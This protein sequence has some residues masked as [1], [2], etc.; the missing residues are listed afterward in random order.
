MEV[1]VTGIGLVSALGALEASWRRLL[2]GNS[3]I[4][5]YQP[6]PEQPPRPLALIGPTLTDLSALTQQVVA[7]AVQ[8]A[9]LMLPAPECGVVIGSSRAYQSRWEQRARAAIQER[10]S[11]FK[12]PPP[13]LETLPHMAAIQAA[14]QIGSNGPVLAPMA[15][16]ATG[17]WALAQ[18]FELIQT[19]QCRQVVV[20]GVEAPVTPLTLAGF[21]KM[22][23]LAKTGCYPFDRHREG[24]VLGEGAAVFVLESAQLAR[25]R[26]A[27]VYGQVRGFGLTNDAC[28]ANS[29]EQGGASAMASVKQGYERS[30]ISSSE[31]NY[32][33]AH[34]TGTALNDEFEANL[35]ER[36]FPQGVPVSST[37]GATGHTLG[38]SGAMGAAFSLMALQY[39]ILPPCVG[40]K[41]P[42]CDLDFVRV[43]RQSD[44]NN[45][46]CFSF[47][48]GGQNAVMALGKYAS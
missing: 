32:I 35:I 39:Q 21:D 22:G 26:S 11:T 3:G 23:A 8:D 38:A 4:E 5:Q 36:L 6:F 45:I 1:V 25:Q 29:P 43:A 40:L 33:H 18:G 41:A 47:G 2:A 9:G 42:A 34:G 24:L 10:G 30:G 27:R 44:I 16:C 7:D 15:A 12:L 20:G 46:L 48:F 17:L 28:Y 14:R 31:I 13:W 37:K 19:G